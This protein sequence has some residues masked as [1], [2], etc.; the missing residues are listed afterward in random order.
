MTEKLWD[1]ELDTAPWEEVLAWQR[2]L[3]PD[4]LIGLRDRSPFYVDHLRAAPVEEADRDDAWR[5]IPFVTKDDVRRNQRERPPELLLGTMQSVPS[6][7]IVQVLGSSGTTGNPTFYGLTAD[8]L[9]R[10]TESLANWMTTA[11]VGPG[12]VVALTTGMPIVAGGMPY[13]DAVRRA[14]ATL[15]WIGGQ[16]TERMV[17][18]LE[19]LR[20]DVLMGTASF[21][22]FFA[23]RCE[24][25]LGYPARELPIR[26]ILA[27]GEPGMGHREVRRR[28]TEAWGV[29][30]I[31]EV[32]GLCDVLAG[33]WSQCG[34]GEGM[35]L[36]AARNV[37]VE[38]VDPETGEPIEWTGGATGEAVYTTFTR[39][40]TPMVRY[41]SRDHMRV[42]GTTCA[43]GRT[44]PRVECIGRTDDMLIYKAMNVF[45]ADIRDLVVEMFPE[46]V[47]GPMR[48]RKD[49]ADQV[50]FDDPIP[51]EIELTGGGDT[52]ALARE[53]EES[54]RVA[55]RV[56]VAV[57]PLEPGTIPLGVHKNALT[58]V[59]ETA[60]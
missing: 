45:P 2:S 18:L 15:A 30:R 8:D 26:T 53:I 12:N 20:V 59:R 38:L 54:V 40:A 27:G 7:R 58:Y 13:A 16:T 60:D 49:T 11:G 22:S 4:F 1:P 37:H 44:A 21:V 33:I 39:I 3:M 31:S 32:M 57:E 47:A 17:R 14:G 25:V 46:R 28:V 41:R 5:E 10:W 23:E 6:D 34:S 48:L 36:T 24:E 52:A 55:L 42:V 50:R 35:H 43:C 19:L 29:E 9:E 51:L 56:R